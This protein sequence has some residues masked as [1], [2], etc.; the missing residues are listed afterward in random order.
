MRRIE[1]VV[2][3]AARSPGF[4]ETGGDSEHGCRRGRQRLPRT[5]EVAARAGRRYRGGVR[6][7]PREISRARPTAAFAA[8]GLLLTLACAGARALH[9]TESGL[10]QDVTFDAYSPLSRRAEVAWR[11]ATSSQ[12]PPEAPAAAAPADQPVD[13]AQER[14]VVYVPD[15]MPP[16]GYG[17]FVFVSPSPQ[18]KLPQG[19]ARVMN[20][21]GLIFV[22]AANSGNE[23]DVP[24]RRIP[25]A[26]L[27]YENVRRRY[28]IDAERVY[29]GGFSGG[30]RT[31]LQIALGYPDLF[32]GVLLNAGSDPIGEGNARLPPGD[33]FRRFQESMRVA[34]VSGERDTFYTREDV[35]SRR[36]MREHC[37]FNVS[38]DVTPRVA[39][40]VAG[41]A[42]LDHALDALEK[43]PNADRSE[44]ERCRAQPAS[45]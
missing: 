6:I 18:A 1:F 22:S 5:G 40:E 10:Q 17:V 30:A 45:G 3:A 39:H 26:L 20:K 24:S 12:R 15:E 7:R 28:R 27:G 41:A 38:S 21:R 29:V 32:R 31:A 2:A 36:S 4:C 14:Y 37:V 33:L 13:L 34:Y 23:A 11:M 16:K 25:L 8:V 42:A 35:I 19:W 44:L 9:A 43:P